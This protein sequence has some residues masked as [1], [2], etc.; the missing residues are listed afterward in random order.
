VVDLKEIRSVTDF[1]RNAKTHVARIRKSK[2]PLVLTV[3][4]QAAIVV[5]DAVA[6]QQL[7]SRVGELEDELAAVAAI[8][9]G[10][11]DKRAGRVKPARA[12]LKAL[13][14]WLAHSRW[15]RQST[16]RGASRTGVVVGC[17]E[18][19][20]RRSYSAASSSCSLP[21]AS[22]LVRALRLRWLR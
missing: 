17:A 18:R 1:Q 16:S 9:V 5:Q 21:C 10:L 3:N 15:V 19:V 6:Y 14:I 20:P 22:A 2:A 4:G 11:E 13:G 8:R 7:L 12:A